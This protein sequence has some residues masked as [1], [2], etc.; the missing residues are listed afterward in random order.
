MS[1]DILI[2]EIIRDAMARGE[3]D[4]LPGAGKPLDHTDEETLDSSET[5][6]AQR[7]QHLCALD[8]PATS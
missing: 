2:D 1:L 6:R 5:Q 4:R 8:L 3:F 7:S